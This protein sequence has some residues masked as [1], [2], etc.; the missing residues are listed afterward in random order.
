M[1]ERDSATLGENVRMLISYDADIAFDD[2]KN[3]CMQFVLAYV[4]QIICMKLEH[5]PRI[6]QSS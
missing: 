5:P 4:R 6:S 2:S 1:T 3:R